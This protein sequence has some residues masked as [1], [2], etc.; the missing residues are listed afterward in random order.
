VRCTYCFATFHNLQV[1]FIKIIV[2]RKKTLQDVCINTN[3]KE[4]HDEKATNLAGT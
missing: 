3:K 2:K 4:H 1:S